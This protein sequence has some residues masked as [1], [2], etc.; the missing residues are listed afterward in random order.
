MLTKQKAKEIAYALTVLAISKRKPGMEFLK[1]IFEKLG[2]SPED[3]RRI[4]R[5]FFA[6]FPAEE[7][8]EAI[9][10]IFDDAFKFNKANFKL[11]FKEASARFNDE[12]MVFT[13]SHGSINVGEKVF[14]TYKGSTQTEGVLVYER[15]QFRILVPVFGATHTIETSEFDIPKDV[16]RKFEHTDA[17]FTNSHGSIK[18]YSAILFKR[19]FSGEKEYGTLIF[20]NGEF[21]VISENA[22]LF[23]IAIGDDKDIPTDDIWQN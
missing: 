10:M 15:G 6:E 8:E 18:C 20:E 5:E 14:F 23:T 4:M 3:N 11:E 12:E 2:N 9:E 13:N 17:V 21:K 22:L 1:S 16:I 19:K 7:V